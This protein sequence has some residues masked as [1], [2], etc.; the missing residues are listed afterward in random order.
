MR[1]KLNLTAWLPRVNQEGIEEK[2]LRGQLFL[3]YGGFK[4]L[5]VTDEA[6]REKVIQFARSAKG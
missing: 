3:K 4:A 5:P 1:T 6:R 2:N